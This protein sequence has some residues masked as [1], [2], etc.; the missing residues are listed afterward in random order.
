MN[1]LAASDTWKIP[2]SEKDGTGTPSLILAADLLRSIYPTD[3]FLKIISVKIIYDKSKFSLD[4]K[5][6]SVAARDGPKSSSTE[7]NAGQ[8][9][10][11]DE[12]RRIN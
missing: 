7:K 11:H 12:I 4:P 1:V 5:W 8:R 9:S 10:A 3:I 6:I 2:V